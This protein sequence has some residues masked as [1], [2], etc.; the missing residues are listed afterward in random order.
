MSTNATSP[1]P[2]VAAAPN[3]VQDLRNRIASEFG[4][5]KHRPTRIREGERLDSVRYFLEC[6]GWSGTDRRFFEAQPY[7]DPVNEVNGLRTLFRAKLRGNTIAQVL[8]LVWGRGHV[9]L[10]RRSIRRH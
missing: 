3:K 2:P 8:H 7:I 4:P 1:K 9:W 10:W 6:I 5:K